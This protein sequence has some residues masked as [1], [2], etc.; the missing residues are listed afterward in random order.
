[1]KLYIIGNGFD[2]NHGLPTSYWNYRD[3][4]AGNNSFLAS[5]YERSEYLQAAEYRD[6][7]KWND[8]EGG[9][10]LQSEDAVKYKDDIKAL[11]E[12]GEKKEKS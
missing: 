9:L 12:N 11:R 4:L 5:N 10:V 6:D 7:T 1:M 8:V 3:Y 2:L